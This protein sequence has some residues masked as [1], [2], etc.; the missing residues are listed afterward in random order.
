MKLLLFFIVMS[1]FTFSQS[2]AAEGVIIR[3]KGE[4]KLKVPNEANTSSK[5]A[6]MPLKK[7]DKVPDK[8]IIQTEKK[9]FLS[10]QFPQSVTINIGAKTSFKVD[11]SKNG[12]ASSY[13]L[14]FGKMRAMIKK[15]LSQD[16]QIKFNNKAVALGVRGTEF[17]QNLYQVGG[18]STSD[19]ALLKGKLAVDASASSKLKPFELIAGESFNTSELA[20]KGMS[21]VK[22]IPAE[23]LKGLLNPAQFMNNLQSASGAFAPVGLVA[24]GGLLAAGS[25]L[26]GGAGLLASAAVGG[27]QK[28]EQ[29][30]QPE[31]PPINPTPIQKEEPK[32]PI[33]K[34][35]A[36]KQVAKPKVKTKVEGLIGFKYVIKEEPQDIREALLARKRDLKRNKC[37]YWIYRQIGG[38]GKKERF[39]RERDCD[40]YDY[41]L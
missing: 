10:I 14:L 2:Y 31:K 40:E 5:A 12:K 4:A 36:V 28:Q 7:G 35:L 21:A 18:K 24:A 25:L 11:L 37:Y 32:K 8:A 34:K 30:K 19:V 9:S 33:A 1:L 39:K 26:K 3:L 38:Y 41:D 27:D 22:K 13:Q 23:I 29:D 20:L 16:E 6:W 15:K 17:L